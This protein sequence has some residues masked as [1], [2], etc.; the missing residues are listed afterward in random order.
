MTSVTL[1]VP[2][3]T[4]MH[5]VRRINEVLGAVPGVEKVNA[6]VAKLVRVDYQGED[7]IERVR[8]KLVEIGC[9]PE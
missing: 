3:I 1:R 2:S 7:V 9:P 4:C 8:A 5:C 6:D